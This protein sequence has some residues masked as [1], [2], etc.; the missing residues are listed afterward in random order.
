MRNHP[1]FT[2]IQ[3]LLAAWMLWALT[4]NLQA[5]PENP[6][7]RKIVESALKLI[8]TPEPTFK[9]F[10]DPQSPVE[11]EE[12]R[13]AARAGQAMARSFTARDGQPI[14]AF[15][16]PRES[17]T[18]ILLIHGVLSRA[19]AMGKAATLLRE[20]ADAEVITLD[21]RGHGRSAG[22][23]G[24]VDYIDQYVDDIADVI[25]A[26]RQERPQQRIVLAGHS[27]GGGI[28]LRYAMR[29]AV[30]AVDAYLLFAPLL[31]SNSPTLFGAHTPEVDP[32]AEPFLKLHIQRIMG[33]KLLS[34]LDNHTYDSLRVLF[35]NVPE[36]AS[37][38]SYSYRANESMAPADYQAGLRAVDKPLLVLV[39]SH[40]E[41]FGAAAF[42]PAVHE[43]SKGSAF[44]YEG[45]SHNGILESR[46]AMQQI[47]KW[48][49]Q[50]K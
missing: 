40:D 38:R 17:E 21:L 28:S 31:G 47:R 46:A 13:E 42:A 10:P 33:L 48:M 5:Q 14:A 24:D 25:A 44:V 41:A 27:M 2:I 12:D 20:T 8:H 36:E 26:I 43:F 15:H 4:G 22:T 39:G 34:T 9:S 18:T 50:L 49:V 23:P 16:F 6:D 37:P 19:S 35:F 29:E 45:V 32:G 7:S 11:K 1:V 30:P 3:T